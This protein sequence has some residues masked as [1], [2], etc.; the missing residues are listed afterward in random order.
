[1]K[2]RFYIILAILALV[3]W[4]LVTLLKQDFHYGPKIGTAAPVFS[5]KDAKGQDLSLESFRGKL[6]MLNF[7]ATW[8]GPCRQ[9]MP[10]LEAL[11]QK[12]KD[13]DFVV[14]GLSLDEEGWQPVEA[15]LKIIPVNFPILLDKDMRIS[16]LYETY[17][18]PETYLID[19]EGMVVA[20][21][22]GPQDYNQEVFF[23][24]IERILPN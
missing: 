8:C 20:K 6:V 17:R 23:K 21:F 16:E 15:F 2:K 12:Y 9:E 11:Y 19:P 3:V 22:V 18:V 13:R 5:L 14:L 4:G 10:S 24:K 7:W 1:M